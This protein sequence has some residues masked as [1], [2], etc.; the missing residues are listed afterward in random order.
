MRIIGIDLATTAKHR[1]VVANERSRFISPVIK[2]ETRVADLV[3]LRARALE[4]AKPDEEL[5][6]VMEATDINWYPVSVYFCRQAATVHVVNPR[7]SADLARFYK[8]HARSD[9]LSAK[10]LARLP[11]VS[12]ESLYPLVLS[13][14]DYLALQRACKEL[15]RLTV[16]ISAH[17][18]RLQAI[19]RLGW[20]GLKL[21]VFKEAAGPATRWFRDLFYDPRQVVEAG[22]AGLRRAWRA[23]EAYNEDE[24]WFESLSELAKELLDLY[25]DQDTYLDYAAL[26]DEVRREQQRLANVEADAHHVRLRVMRPRYRQLHASRNLETIRGVG[27][28]GAAVYVGFVGSPD[29]FSTNRGFRGWSGMVPRSRQSGE[30][31]TK[32]L[33]ISKAGPDLVKKYAYLDADSARQRDPQIAALYYDQLVNKGNHHTQ[34]VCA[35]ATHLLD[36]VRVIL[37]QD[38]AYELRDVDG[39]PVTPEQARAIV[40]DRHIVPQEV[41][42]R[43]NRRARRQRAERQMERTAKRR[44]RSRKVR[45]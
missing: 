5:V 40:L 34:A 2:F 20:P 27:Q 17:K 41:R 9:R 21:R 24:D 10:V 39:T 33:R 45:G 19:D 15:D 23:A 32:G 42:N 37:T 26:S 3:R 29:R 1:A 38:R 7:M 30:S 18:N 36:R 31:E 44:S 8:R 28:D 43:N 14:A 16:Q 12:P 22:V 6:V 25:G 35:C 4:E 13:G 11:L